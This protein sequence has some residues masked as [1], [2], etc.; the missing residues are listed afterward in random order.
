MILTWTPLS[1]LRDSFFV[2]AFHINYFYLIYVNTIV[3]LQEKYLLANPIFVST[4][5]LCD[6]SS[7]LLQISTV[8]K[9]NIYT[10]LKF[11]SKN[12]KVH[13]EAIW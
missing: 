9:K 7:C 2:L 4:K 6:I 13:T 3:L 5:I 1:P 8:V 11:L 12:H 10:S